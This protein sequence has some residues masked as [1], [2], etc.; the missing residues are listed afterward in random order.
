MMY[1]IIIPAHNEE[2]FIA[3][4]L[5]SILHQT[6]KP[7]QVVIVNDNSTDTTASIINSYAKKYPIFKIVNTTSSTKH[8]PGSKVV[9][10]FNKGLAVI[11]SKYDFIVKLDA[12]IILPNNYFEEIA[13]I[14]MSNQK[15]GIAGGFAYEEDKDGNWILNHPMN[16]DHVRGA[17]KAY[18]KSCFNK[19]NGLR[20]AMGWD[21]VDELL[22]QYHNFTIVTNNNLKVKHL[23]PT[24]NAYNKQAKL[25]QGQAMYRMR[26]GFTISCIASLKMALK[27]KKAAVFLDNLTGYKNAKKE[28]LP[29]LVTPE[30]GNFIRNLRWKNI[31]RKLV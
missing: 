22:A 11:D 13:S 26:Y 14:F 28:K 7:K 15:I 2:A 30:E 19:I 23:R 5:D 21:T 6:K 18:S 8:M 31:K 12:D 1:Y 17:F 16:K 4:T 3:K 24:G 27:Q 29:F 20:S 25:L 9:N 10:A